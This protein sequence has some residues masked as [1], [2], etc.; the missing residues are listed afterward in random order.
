MTSKS[1]V[2]ACLSYLG[3]L[4]LIPL[5]AAKDDEFV[6]FHVR[7]GAKLTIF[8]IIILSVVRVVYMI[9]AISGLFFGVMFYQYM[10]EYIQIVFAVGFFIV[11][12]FGIIS[13][14]IGIIFLVL[15]ILG[16]VN[17][18]RGLTTPLPIIGKKSPAKPS[19]N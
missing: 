17:A 2:L 4:I 7:Q 16:I 14:I 18:C 9:F 3:I 8:G 19:V 6:Q 13:T 5:I 1:K 11:A 12:V 10:E 15:C